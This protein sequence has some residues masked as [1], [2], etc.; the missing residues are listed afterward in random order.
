[1]RIIFLNIAHGVFEKTLLDFIKTFSLNTDA[2][3]FQEADVRVCKQI[4][5][6]LPDFVLFQ[7]CK[8][9]SSIGLYEQA[10]FFR[11]NLLVKKKKDMSDG[12]TRVG[13]ANMFSLS[14]GLSDLYISNIHGVPRPG[15]KKDNLARIR[16][17]AQ[18]INSNS[19]VKGPRI[20]GGDFNL[21]PD[22]K[23]IKMFEEQGYLNLIKENKIKTTRNSHAWIQAKK[24]VVD[25]Y[26]FYG[27]QHFAD[28]VFVSKDVKVKNFKVP[29]V[30]I[31]DHLP[32]ILDFEI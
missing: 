27:E 10:S 26:W 16:Q 18:I 9:V 19:K 13:V 7:S 6:I 25:G 11:K 23:S 4:K 17:T 20:I 32:L 15:D 12:D 1:M 5:K 29:N 22:T 8:E 24:L 30:E 3:C 2:F 14:L 31:S 28:Y 21:L